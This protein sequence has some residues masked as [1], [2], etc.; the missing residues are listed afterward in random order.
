MFSFKQTQLD[1]Q[2]NDIQMAIEFCKEHNDID[3]WNSLINESIDKPFIMSKLLDGI[4]GFINPEILVNKI[5]MGQEIPGL[6]NSLVKL[7][8]GF[9]LQVSIQDGCNEILV[10]DY[11]N[12]H[13][14]LSNIQ[15][16]ATFITNENTCGMCQRDI[17]VKGGFSIITFSLLTES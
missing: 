11:Y 12:L 13:K 4:S 7:L 1:S 17:I 9:S 8:C 15:Q 16:K 14:K 6:K 10:T 2:I 5:K 3:L